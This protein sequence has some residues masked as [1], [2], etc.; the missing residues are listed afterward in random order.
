MGRNKPVLGLPQ[1][2]VMTLESHMLVQ[3]FNPVTTVLYDPTEGS[4]SN[5]F[6]ESRGF[7]AWSL[8][9]LGIHKDGGS[10]SRISNEVMNCWRGAHCDNLSLE[11]GD[12][13]E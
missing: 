12:V 7:R 1:V 8:R 11:I 3:L 2:K 9:C 5:V 4:N 10:S 6:L 13:S